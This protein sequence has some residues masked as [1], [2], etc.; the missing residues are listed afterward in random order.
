MPFLASGRALTLS[1]TR[2]FVK[3][4]VDA[5]YGE[6][7]GVH[8]LGLEGSE[9]IGEAVLAMHLEATYRDFSSCIHGHPTL[10]EVMMEAALAVDGKAVHL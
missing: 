3:F 2:G 5:K 1:E 7:L 4:V 6:I 9:M 10:S 8:V